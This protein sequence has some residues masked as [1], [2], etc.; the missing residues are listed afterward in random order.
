[1]HP[2][3]ALFGRVPDQHG[4][5][6]PDAVEAARAQ[7]RLSGLGPWSIFDYDG[8][9]LPVRTYRGAA[10]D[11][12]TRSAVLT[13]GAMSF[14]QPAG[15]PSTYADLLRERGPGLHHVA[16]R[17]PSAAEAR[18]HLLARGFVEEMR[19]AGHGLDG[20]GEF[21]ILRPPDWDLIGCYL[22]LLESPARRRPPV[23][24]LTEP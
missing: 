19:G 17:V 13:G 11:F 10:A 12:R 21:S 1:M 23:T 5:V 22:E 15:G 6:V 9:A 20:D 3:N 7:L 24:L 18:E 14:I 16:Y 4:F 8:A 2:L